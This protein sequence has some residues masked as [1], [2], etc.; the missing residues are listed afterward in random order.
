MPS[1]DPVQQHELQC[2]LQRMINLTTPNYAKLDI[3]S[4]QQGRANRSLPVLLAPWEQDAPCPEEAF[5]A[6]TKDLTASGICV[7]LHQPVHHNQFLLAFWDQGPLYALAEVRHLEHLGGPFWQMG[8][9][10]LGRL[11]PADIPGRE[12]LEPK[13]RYLRPRRS[14][15]HF[16]VQL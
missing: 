12:Q 13:V 10:L 6:L 11:H 16:P 7:V 4:R 8:L 2:L 14:G 3:D 1:L 15:E 5:Y 9:E